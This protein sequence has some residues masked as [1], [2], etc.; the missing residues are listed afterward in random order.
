MVSGVFA[1]DPEKMSLQSC[2]PVIH[3]L[4][5]TYGGLIKGMIKKPKKKNKKIEEIK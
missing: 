4:E 2:F 5:K 3:D 1:G